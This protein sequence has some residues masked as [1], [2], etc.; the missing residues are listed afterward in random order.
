MKKTS[1]ILLV[2]IAVSIGILISF[3]GNLTTYDT[4]YSATKKKNKFV[5]LIAKIDN[6]E[7]VHYDAINN[8]NLFIFYATDSLGGKTK[9]IYNNVK[10]KDI[11]KSTRLVLKGKMRTDYF[12]C[13]EILMKCPS[14]YK[15]DVS[16]LAQNT[17][18][19]N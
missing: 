19:V 15:E 4:I 16:S 14:K 13:N 8:P 3:S 6:S 17:I 5:H 10:P 9:V 7:N 2:L 12:E 18:S 1:I 11:E